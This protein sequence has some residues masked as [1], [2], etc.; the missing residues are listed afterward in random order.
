MGGW[1]Q[2]YDPFNNPA[3]SA[4]MAAIPIVLL[5]AIIAIAIMLIVFRYLPEG[6]QPDPGISLKPRRIIESFLAIL[7]CPRYQDDAAAAISAFWLG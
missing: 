2:V 7:E 6:H 4:A 3:I 5:L 1:S